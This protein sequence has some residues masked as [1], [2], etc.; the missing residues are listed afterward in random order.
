MESSSSPISELLYQDVFFSAPFGIYTLD[1]VGV[2]TSFNPKMAELS[3]NKPENAVGLNALHLKSYKNVGLDKLFIKGIAGKAFETEVEYHSHLANKKTIRH[4]RG[5]PIQDRGISGQARLLLIVEDITSR[6]AMEKEIKDEETR[7]R[8]SIESLSIGYIMTGP[9]NEMLLINKAA[10]AIFTLDTS[11]AYPAT[12]AIDVSDIKVK[13]DL[14]FIQETLGDKINLVKQLDESR[15]E[16][17]NI[18]IKDISYKILR[19]NL[20]ITP[21]INKTTKDILGTVL[22]IEDITEQKIMERSRDEF[23]S[24]ASHE[25]RTPLTAIRG[26]TSLIQTYFLDDIKN[27]EVINIIQDVHDASLR[28]ISIVN[29]FL[30]MSRLEQGKLQYH[31]Q[32][33]DI[34]GLCENIIR[35]YDVTGSRKKLLLEIIKPELPLP[36]VY[37]DRDRT[38]E[39]LSNLL[40]N[41][42]KFTSKGGVKISFDLLDNAIKIYVSDTGEGIP[43]DSQALLFRKFQQAQADLLTRDVSHGTGLGLYISKMMAKCMGG[44]V[45]LEKSEVG[46]GTTFSLTITKA[47]ES[48][49][50]EHEDKIQTSSN[51]GGVTN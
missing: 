12:R 18:S 32:V 47:T 16:R 14:D 43:E 8:A 9:D 49:I 25:L 10:K 11:S 2:I 33:F 36:V 51:P 5:I 44:D 17:K 22:L 31:K 50:K 28:L 46:K 19:L 3:G 42:I 21:I 37:A 20:H 15:R 1:A 23:F 48:Q 40:G 29:D 35:E 7:L 30:D 39:I 41:G 13:I 27:T 24:I 34:Y 38:R 4:Y 26:N 6:K 45:V